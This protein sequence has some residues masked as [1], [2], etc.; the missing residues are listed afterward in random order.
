MQYCHRAEVEGHPVLEGLEPRLLLSSQ[1]MITELMAVNTSGLTDGWG[2]TRDWLEIYNPAATEADLT[3][4]KLKDGGNVWPFPDGTTIG[5]KEF[6]VVFASDENSVDPLGYLHTNFK[7]KGGGEYLG[8][9]DDE[10]QVVHEYADGYPE[11][12]ADVSYGIAQDLDITELVAPGDIAAY[13]VPGSGEL[14]TTWTAKDFDDTLW[15]TGRTGLG[16]LASVPG[17]AVTNYLS[18]QTVSST[19]VAES[20]IATASYQIAVHRENAPVVNYLDTNGAAHYTGDS[21]FPGM[22]IGQDGSNYVL[23]ATGTITIPSAGNWTFG[24]NSDDGFRVDLTKGSSSFS[25]EYPNPRGP[26]DTLRTFY[27]PQAGDYD[28]RLI[29]FE[30]GGGAEVEFWAAQ[31]SY[32]GFDYGAFHLVGDTTSGG[33]AVRSQSVGG[34]GGSDLS[35][36]IATDVTGEMYGTNASLYARIPFTVADPAALTSLTLRMKYDDGYVAYLDGAEVARQNAAGPPQWDSQATASRSDA[37]ATSWQNVDLTAWLAQLQ[38]GEHVLAIHAL[39]AADD[40]MDFLLLPGLAQ[41]LYTP[42]DEHFFTAATPGEPNSEEF[43]AGVAD[44]R[45]SHDRGFYDA[46]V[47]VEITCETVGAAIYYTLDGSEPSETHGTRYT[48]PVRVEGTTTLRARAYQ[49]GLEPSNVDTHTYVFLDDVITQSPSGE[50]PGPGWPT[51]RVN[52]Q[53]LDYGMDPQ[54]VNNPLYAGTIKDDLQAVATISL[55]TDLANLFDPANGI[56]VNADQDG[57]A[58]ER[59]TSVELIDPDGSDGFQIDAGLRIRGGYSR[60]D[61]NPKHA[62]RLF[63]RAEYGDATLNFPLFGDEGADQFQK[64]DLRCTQ[65]YS[66]SYGGDSR[67]T[68][69]RDVFSRDM[70]REMG[71][72]YTRSRYYHLYVNGVYWGLFQTQER[73]EAAYAETYFGGNR[74]DYDTVKVGSG[75]NI[76]ATDGNLLAWQRLWDAAM[77]GFQS[78]AAYYRVQGLNP[79]GT[80]NPDY[81]PLLD[82]DNLIDYMISSIYVGDIDGPVSNFLGNNSPNNWYGLYNRENPTGFKFFRHDAEHTLGVA[83]ACYDRTGPYAAGQTFQKSNPMWI[84]QKLCFHADYR[85]RFADHVHRHFFNGGILTPQAAGALLAPRAAEIDRA[86]VA[87]S[88]RW[89]DAK[90]G[91]P[92]TRDND[93]LPAVESLLNSYFPSRTGIVLNQLKSYDD[94]GTSLPLYSSVT[95]PTFH[96]NGSYQHGGSMRIGDTL[97]I[98]APAGTI[99]YTLDGSDIYLPGGARNPDAI[100]YT[101]AV[102]LDRS[103]HVKARVWTGSAWSALTEAT[104]YGDVAPSL[105]ISEIMYH[106]ADPTPAEIAAGFDDDGLFEF[107]E[108]RNIDSDPLPIGGV[109][110]SDGIDFTFPDIVLPAHGRAVVVKDRD[111]FEFRYGTGAAVIAGEYD[112]QLDNG[113]ERIT[114]DSP[115][116]GFVHDFRYRDGWFDHTDGGGFSLTVRDAGQELALWDVK[117][118]W[119]ASHAPGGS[120][121][122]GDVGAPP[123]AVVITEVLAHSDGALGDWIELHNT[124]DE[125]VDIGGWF[126]SDSAGDL[127]EYQFAAETTI[128]DGAYVVFSQSA[129]FGAAFA[130]SELGDDVYL[131]SNAGGVAGGYREHVDFGASPREFTFGLHTKSTGATDFVLLSRAT[132]AEPNAY[133]AVGPVV[134]NE[135]MY[136]PADPTP[137][138]LAAGFPNDDD[139][140]FLELRNTSD[141][142][143]DLRDFYLSDGIAFTFGWYD[144]DDFETAVW[145]RQAGATATWT[146]TLPSSGQWEVLAWWDAADAQGELRRLDSRAVYTIDHRDGTANVAINQSPDPEPDTPYAPEWVSLGTYAFNA[147]DVSVTLARGATEPGEWTMADRVRFV[148]GGSTVTADN[149]DA[150]FVASEAAV[151]TLGPGEHVVVVS[152]QAA[153]E[154]RYDAAASGI[155][156]A[157]QYTGHLSNDGESVKLFRAADPEPNGFIPYVRIDRVNYNDN[158]PWPVE[159]DGSGAALSRIVSKQYG[160]DVG[161]WGA[162]ALGGTPGAE[163]TY[164]DT[165]PPTVP[166]GLAAEAVVSPDLRVELTW[167]ASSEPQSYV[168]HYVIYRNG[169]P[170][171]TTP[172]TGYSDTS[173]LAVT[174]YSYRVAAVNRDGYASDLSAAVDTSIAG[175]GEIWATDEITVHAVFTEALDE[176]SAETVANYTIDGL[177]VQS[178][179]LQGDGVTVALTTSIMSGGTTYVLVVRNVETVSGHPIP[180]NT[181]AAFVYAPQGSGTIL[182]EYWTRIWGS[183]VNDLTRNSAFPDNPSGSG[184]LTIFEGPVNWDRSYGTRLRGYV[185]PPL[186]GSYTFWIAADDSAELYLSTDQSPEHATRIAYVDSWTDSRE[187]SKY[188]SQQSA[189]VHLVAGR[190][191]YIEALHKENW[192][193]DNIAVGWRLPDGTLERPI[194]GERLSPWGGDVDPPIVAV[195]P[196]VTDDPTPRLTGTV[197]DPDAAIVV[198]VR[199]RYYSAVNQRSGTWVL[200]DNTIS[201]ALALGTYDVQVRAT[202]LAGNVGLDTTTNELTIEP[203]PPTVTV[204]ELATTDRTPPLSGTVDDPE[205]AIVVTV[206]GTPYDAVNRG[207][208]TWTLADDTIDPPLADGAYDVRAVAT[209]LAGKTGHDGTTNE[210]VVDNVPPVVTVDPLVTDVGTPPL[211]GTVDDPAATVRLVIQGE[212]YA[213]VNRGDGTWALADDVIDPALTGG[214]YDVAATAT[215]RAGNVGTDGT[216]GE[217][218]V[219]LTPPST[220]GHL[221]AEAVTSARID[222][223]WGAC[224]DP[225]SGVAYYVLYRNGSAHE[226]LDALAYSDTGLDQAQTYTYRVAAVSTHG[227]EGAPSQP[228]EATP[229]PGV[230]SVLGIDPT[231]LVVTFGKPVEPTTAET[232]ANYTLDDEA[233]QPVSI[234]SAS[235]DAEHANEVVLAFAQPLVEG[236][237]YT[238]TVAKVSDLAG[239]AVEGDSQ[240]VF[241]FR[242]VDPDLLAWWTFDEGD[243]ATAPDATGNERHLDVVGATW[244]EE[245]IL[246]GAFLFDGTD[247]CLVDEDGEAYVNGLS[248]FTVSMWVKAKATGTDKG[249]FTVGPPGN[250]DC[251]SLRHDESGWEGG[252]PDT[253]KCF[254]FA[255]LGET[256]IEGAANTQTTDWQ[257]VALTWS[258]GAVPVLYLD[259]D[260]QVLSDKGEPVSGAVA[261]ATQVLIGKGERGSSY[262]WEGLIDDVRIYGRQ[263]ADGEVEALADAPFLVPPTVTHFERNDGQD[264]PSELASISVSFSQDVS[265][266]LDAS[267]LSIHNDSTDR[268]VDLAAA[269]VEYVAETNTARWDLSGVAVEP[270]YHTATLSGAGVTNAD[271]LPLGGS[272]DDYRTTFLVALPGDADSDG[273]VGRSDFLS[274]RGSFGRSGTGWPGGDLDYDGAVDALDYVALK[275]NIGRSVAPA[276]APLSDDLSPAP[277]ASPA[278][279]PSEDSGTAATDPAVQAAGPAP[280]TT[281]TGQERPLT[282]LAAE[283]PAVGGGEVALPLAA[284]VAGQDGERFAA[285]PGTAG[286]VDGPP[287]PSGEVEVRTDSDGPATVTG[288]ALVDALAGRRLAIAL[289]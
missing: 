79:D 23:E 75:Y 207:N 25:F 137:E 89:G 52:G 109:R 26:G 231:H 114:L 112:G 133:P 36:L 152:N 121:G 90:S 143:V 16:Y 211:S 2:E 117:E 43:W 45:F 264:R 30:Q 240:V 221:A 126:L 140:E 281:A 229:R 13:L 38:A 9:L 272:G 278:A 128:E 201:P 262:A 87:E 212:Q 198:A 148:R 222:L 68:F 166:T 99:Y 267:D 265:D 14:G 219:D 158:L 71:Q 56:Y 182:R 286:P 70:Q 106:P 256:N 244:S 115:L 49:E 141:Q 41:I 168:D 224:E 268:D 21:A 85:M 236:A 124:T 199:G 173:V 130:L 54:V 239:N 250:P 73:S 242:D 97:T 216:T 258:S 283:D 156:V 136:H 186:T 29:Y 76:M 257:H 274:L 35:A 6:L 46:P 66:W 288:A 72:P 279:A 96:V 232:A 247:D 142:P 116:G 165:T 62:W 120:P 84:H 118:G 154:E 282:A 42:L 86:I 33:L 175:I 193:D 40:D 208:G 12:T 132:L 161:N 188:G 5:P 254:L 60:S 172:A 277:D 58:W 215:D 151:T 261:D 263:L 205:A 195:A 179:A 101:G 223:A 107:I 37:E 134:I 227:F 235:R 111:A 230:T 160:N 164:I 7:L 104:Y 159:A 238:L 103:M 147:V 145:T 51:G 187:W 233:G 287:A 249:F 171:A 32:S 245:G 170:H 63:F 194:P 280:A 150:S 15:S 146:A 18:N 157:G 65:N 113:G 127:T 200:P 28:V 31:G 169:L 276:A 248:A 74:D 69:L 149:G 181:E 53:V 98:T 91:T 190:R 3:G 196:L 22:T 61:D 57:I 39:N 17:F 100:A 64:I 77:A 217:I 44:T 88:A 251:L 253:F 206:A 213:A 246:G 197:D 202:D 271:G 269:T 191:Y 102:T 94:G 24:V 180:A 50:A 129:H 131:S 273:Q 234:D 214:T 252:K 78:D 47:D 260:V 192:S 203:P 81:E 135:I 189:P 119:R 289:L 8:L 228:V 34:S 284:P 4:W 218:F 275:R 10:G 67:N 266:G 122:G 153:F 241:V 185:H 110:F 95:A 105:R 19:A 20:V 125:D 177:T 55:V 82:V 174:P 83:S 210:L 209:S 183:R 48:V 11:Q 108:V 93:W 59:P 1:P 270:G 162:S 27:L 123:G 92:K 155:P 139:F 255:T 243:P 176:T 285:W 178:A 163:N 167:D 225:E 259:G 237:T 204:Y 80:P 220:P 138:E 226:T 144:T 184:E